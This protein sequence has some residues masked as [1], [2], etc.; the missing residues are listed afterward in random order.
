VNR[1][2]TTKHLQ[3]KNKKN[4]L[5]KNEKNRNKERKHRAAKNDEVKEQNRLQNKSQHEERRAALND[6]EREQDKESH[7]VG[8]KNRKANL[9]DEDREQDRQ[10]NK[11]QH[12]EKYAAFSPEDKEKAKEKH[13]VEES[14]RRNTEKEKKNVVGDSP[15]PAMPQNFPTDRYLKTFEHNPNAAQSL[16]WARTHNWLFR[17]YRNK[18][19]NDLTEDEI[20]NLIVAMKD[21]ALVSENDIE[22]AMSIY[23]ERMDPN[24]QEVGC[25]VCGCLDIPMGEHFEDDYD[26]KKH[27]RPSY[28]NKFIE[29]SLRDDVIRK[30]YY[31]EDQNNQYN[32]D[33]PSHIE[34]N[35]DNRKRWERYKKVISNIEEEINDKMIRIHLYP[36]LC[37]KVKDKEGTYTSICEHCLGILKKN[38]GEL[39]DD[40]IANGCDLGMP[41]RAGLPE[42]TIAEECAITKVR[43]LSTALN[44]RIP[45]STTVGKYSAVKGHMVAFD[46]TSADVCGR[47]MPDM[48]HLAEQ[49]ILTLE[50][51]ELGGIYRNRLEQMLLTELGTLF[52]KPENVVD[53]LHALQFLSVDWYGDLEVKEVEEAREIL[54]QFRKAVVENAVT[55]PL[56]PTEAAAGVTER[57]DITRPYS[58]SQGL[59]ENLLGEN[60]SQI[61][62][63]KQDAF[64]KLARL[65][66]VPETKTLKRDYIRLLEGIRSD[67]PHILE[68]Q[69]QDVAYQVLTILNDN[70]L[71]TIQLLADELEKIFGYPLTVDQINNL[72]SSWSSVPNFHARTKNEM[73]TW[74]S[75]FL[76][77]GVKSIYKN[78]GNYE[79]ED[80]DDIDC[81]NVDNKIK[82][83]GAIDDDDDNDDDDNAFNGHDDDGKDNH[84]SHIKAASENPTG[85]NVD[86]VDK[87]SVKKVDMLDNLEFS[88]ESTCGA[89][90]LQERFPIVENGRNNAVKDVLKSIMKAVDGKPGVTT[91]RDDTMLN[92]YVDRDHI[93]Y[94]GFPTVFPLGKGL[95]PGN[96]PLN[97]G[98][99]RFLINHFSRRV[100]RN[101]KCLITLHNMKYKSDT[102]RVVAAKVLTD[103]TELE[104]FHSIITNANLP[105]MI[106]EA[107]TNPDSKEAQEFLKKISKV[108]FMTGSKIPF[109]PLERGTKAAVQLI[110][111]IR[112]YGLPNAFITVAPDETGC[113]LIARIACRGELNV[114]TPKSTESAS[115]FWWGVD[116]NSSEDDK[117]NNVPPENFSDYANVIP[118]LLQQLP[119][120]IEVWR[121]DIGDAITRDP[122]AVALLCQRLMHSLY[123]GLFGLPAGQRKTVINFRNK[124]TNME[125]NDQKSEAPRGLFG[126]PIAW[127]DVSELQGRKQLHWHGLLFG[128]LPQW[129]MQRC[130]G[131]EGNDLKQQ[132]RNLGE[133]ISNI[134]QTSYCAHAPPSVHANY[135]LRRLHIANHKKNNNKSV[136]KIQRKVSRTDNSVAYM[137]T[138]VSRN[139]SQNDERAEN[140]EETDDNDS[141]NSDDIFLGRVNVEENSS[142]NNKKNSNVN[143]VDENYCSCYDETDDNHDSNTNLDVGHR[144]PK[145][146]PAYHSPPPRGVLAKDIKEWGMTT[147]VIN[148][149]HGHCP[150]CGKGKRGEEGCRLAYG[151]ATSNKREP[152]ELKSKRVNNGKDRELS[153]NIALP[154]KIPNHFNLNKQEDESILQRINRF[155]TPGG[156][157]R[158]IN[159][160]IVRPIQSIKLKTNKNNNS[161]SSINENV[162]TLD[163]KERCEI[164]QRCY[165]RL[166]SVCEVIGV[167]P[168][169]PKSM[170]NDLDIIDA[171]NATNEICVL[172]IMNDPDAELKE[173]EILLEI[174]KLSKEEKVNFIDYFST[175]NSQ[176][177]ESNTAVIAAIGSSFNAQPLTSTTSALCAIFY[178][179]DYMTKDTLQPAALFAFVLAARRRF[180]SVKGCAPEGEDSQEN[181]RPVKRIAQI[182]LNGVA[183]ATEIGVQQCALNVYGLPAHNASDIFSYVF[184]TPAI[185]QVRLSSNE[186]NKGNTAE[187]ERDINS[188][189]GPS[190]CVYKDKVGF[191]E[192]ND[193]D[194]KIKDYDKKKKFNDDNNN[195]NDGDED[196]VDD[197]VVDD[198]DADDDDDDDD[199]PL[200]NNQ[201][202]KELDAAA[203]SVIPEK[204]LGESRQNKDGKVF[205]TSQDIQ[206][207]HRGPQLAFLSL[208]EY[209]C[210]VRE[211]SKKKEKKEKEIEEVEEVDKDEIKDDEEAEE[212]EK[213]E[214]DN[215]NSNDDETD[216]DNNDKN[217]KRKGGNRK[218]NGRYDFLSPHNENEDKIQALTSLITVPIFGGF[219]ALPRWPDQGGDRKMSVNDIHK[220]R[221]K[222]AEWVFGVLVPWPAPGFT[223]EDAND[224]IVDRLFRLLGLLEEGKFLQDENGDF[225]GPPG[226]TEESKIVRDTED[227]KY[228]IFSQQCIAQFIGDMAKGLKQASTQLRSNHLT[229]RG[230]NAQKWSNEDPEKLLFPTDYARRNAPQSRGDE[231]DYNTVEDMIKFSVELAKLTKED[232]DSDNIEGCQ[233]SGGNVQHQKMDSFLHNMTSSLKKIHPTNENINS[234]EKENG[235]NQ[236][237]FNDFEANNTLNIP[238]NIRTAIYNAIQTEPEANK[239]PKVQIN[240]LIDTSTFNNTQ[241]LAARA[242]DSLTT[243][244]LHGKI[245]DKPNDGQTKLLREVAAYFDEVDQGIVDKTTITKNKV[246]APLIFLDGPAGSGKSFFFACVENL[247]DAIKRNISPTAMT[248]V[249]ATNIPTRALVRTTASLFK[250]GINPSGI[251]PLTNVEKN[252]MMN[253]FNNPIA[254]IVDEIGFADPSFIWAIDCRLKDF[255]GN[256]LP[257]G[258]I[259][260]IL[261]GDLYQLPPVRGGTFYTHAFDQNLSNIRND[262]R[263]NLEETSYTN[264]ELEL[265][266]QTKNTKKVEFAEST[267]NEK[268]THRKSKSKKEKKRKG[269]KINE[270]N[271]EIGK[272]SE[273][274]NVMALGMELFVD[275]KRRTFTETPRFTDKNH[276]RICANLRRG[277]TTG[278]K[279]YLKSH[280]LKTKDENKGFQDSVIMSPGN[281]ERELLNPMLLKYYGERNNERVISWRVP[282]EFYGKDKKATTSMKEMAG[283][284]SEA[285]LNQLNPILFN[286]FCRNA[287]IVLT[288]N[289]NALRGLANGVKSKMISLEWANPDIRTRALEFLSQNPGH[290]TLPLGLE[291]ITI[292][293]EPVL[294]DALKNSWPETMTY[295]KGKIVIPLERKK[296]TVVLRAGNC[297]IRAS[298]ETLQYDIDY[299]GTIHKAQG[300]T[301]AKAIVS[302]LVRPGLPSRD[303]FHAIYVLLTRVREGDDFRILSD[304]N[305]D[306][307][308]RLRPPMRLE[309][310]LDGYNSMGIFDLNEAVDSFEQRKNSAERSDDN[311]GSKKSTHKTNKKIGKKKYIYENKNNNVGKAS[312]KTVKVDSTS[313]TQSQLDNTSEGT[314][315]RVNIESKEET[316]ERHGKIKIA[317]A[318][319]DKST[320]FGSPQVKL[321]VQRAIT[322]IGNWTPVQAGTGVLADMDLDTAKKAISLAS[323]NKQNNVQHSAFYVSF[324]RSIFNLNYEHIKF[325]RNLVG[326]DDYDA[327]VNRTRL[328]LQAAKI[329]SQ[330]IPWITGSNYIEEQVQHAIMNVEKRMLESGEWPLEND[331]NNR[332]V[333]FEPLTGAQLFMTI[334]G[335]KLGEAYK[336]DKQEIKKGKKQKSNTDKIIDITS[337]LELQSTEE[338]YD[339]GDRLSE[340]P[341]YYGCDS[342]KSM[343]LTLK[344]DDVMVSGEENSNMTIIDS[345]FSEFKRKFS[346]TEESDLEN[347]FVTDFQIFL[348]ENSENVNDEIR[349][350]LFRKDVVGPDRYS[351]VPPDGTCFY[352][353]LELLGL[354]RDYL[355][356]K[357]YTRRSIPHVNKMSVPKLLSNTIES[358]AHRNSFIKKLNEII[359]PSLT[360]NSIKNKVEA[361][362]EYLNTLGE[363]GKGEFNKSIAM[364]YIPSFLRDKYRNLTSL[365][366]DFYGFIT[367]GNYLPELPGIFGIY[368]TNN[369]LNVSNLYRQLFQKIQYQPTHRLHMIYNISPTKRQSQVSQIGLQTM[370]LLAKSPNDVCFDGSHFF[371]KD[372]TDPQIEETRLQEALENLLRDLWRKRKDIIN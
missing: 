6:E 268:Q 155:S 194:D 243:H 343:L 331:E 337:E 358:I 230:R 83:D 30:L 136:A 223:Y 56:N 290:V 109:S 157:R 4:E 20:E 79:Y 205:V 196:C 284:N 357:G 199:D 175:L 274:L 285:K 280:Q 325:V 27:P 159:Y 212:E 202:F 316:S 47:I 162:V 168:I 278:L 11:K 352:N 135:T 364:N 102:A 84:Y 195:D 276:A 41:Q 105:D 256:R 367:V 289:T 71:Q 247:A 118:T 55:L 299:V 236:T 10:L 224:D 104:E 252:K 294:C 217:K 369:F 125:N 9:G 113:A 251:K 227:H 353:S 140:Y 158:H 293:H 311:K 129:I 115:Q 18:D 363:R 87:I 123:E 171:I 312:N 307:I 342:V 172:G 108:L 132:S 269:Q 154:H 160:S 326:N 302:L 166:L 173:K 141:V 216:D 365:W 7:R 225:V 366:G 242:L 277:D 211:K 182:V 122:T 359:I 350:C 261:S 120:G 345:Y 67:N 70:R 273:G 131:A 351:N 38:K 270:D 85:G 81:D 116:I 297:T 139:N 94:G 178:I 8:E 233:L 355:N 28:I 264:Q 254:I 106:K 347:L 138:K 185:R 282:A 213:E 142:H 239:I 370:R 57:S 163:Q 29:I 174:E 33:V 334:V 249:A 51:P 75:L 50:G 372:I 313:N 31:T 169:V 214:E 245:R 301:L 45:N 52:I 26:I 14:N 197:D 320:E 210:I 203:A 147:M 315:S 206:Y 16:F 61:E 327:T 321:T 100:A 23:R 208:T 40:S 134:L 259:C 176:L 226:Y 43:I 336:L 266:K 229:W 271:I 127:F 82:C 60:N 124:S 292:M 39:P 198:D 170:D 330:D 338:I 167:K 133:E 53:W 148:G 58:E 35:E 361:F 21:E 319:I 258:G 48:K 96:G 69:I 42:L 260:V 76:K 235:S 119:E 74:S 88:K 128:G 356:S 228:Y 265:P 63:T 103:S 165:M 164:Q 318:I 219:S 237:N 314:S 204:S 341:I 333:G 201:R 180:Y 90:L 310:F 215:E 110:A 329:K 150:T 101:Q 46:D 186:K 300:S 143:D 86:S 190:C 117:K 287:P 179:I 73:E 335:E 248:G 332:E 1:K 244:G 346:E 189:I 153:E 322:L 354:R 68:A 255:M 295:V 207:N 298:L 80:S 37:Y 339:G 348:E 62:S 98:K 221:A 65:Y 305:L 22:E 296:E 77:L 32:R 279:D 137:H 114:E 177:G 97:K 238:S 145:V 126:R 267:K 72:Q 309:A 288:S 308:D 360:D 328:M 303:D 368:Y 3:K 344:T 93:L 241:G 187:I 304:D 218:G 89:T 306:F 2:R 161:I 24:V 152:G 222:F 146:R 231:S 253:T 111:M 349:F 220:A 291:P 281:P 59:G 91:T 44:V 275:F 340:Y 184:A 5:I 54:E 250:F 151:R 92:S 232:L 192:S 107:E 191:V 130:A 317:T 121:Q 36:E 283:A 49:M 193:G 209:A 19:L 188:G 286:H 257:F 95:G 66:Y 99:R 15:T 25:G 371:P 112:Y 183:G 200:F 272:C 262:A 156:D 64:E 17:D 240:D 362:A 144:L 234:S 324:I 323:H 246:K 13:R 181:L 78:R 263:H 12:K 149:T 34:D